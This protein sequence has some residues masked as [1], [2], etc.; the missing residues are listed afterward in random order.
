[1]TSTRT[2]R[3]PIAPTGAARDFSTAISPSSRR[4]R[5]PGPADLA[6]A[7]FPCQDLSL[8]GGGKGMGAAEDA[9]RTRSGAFWL[10]HEKIRGLRDRAGRRAPSCWKMSSGC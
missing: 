2:R 4:K 5:L 3:P 8:A 6:W 10:F 9:V 7:S 1:M